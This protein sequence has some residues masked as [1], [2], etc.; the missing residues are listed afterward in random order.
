MSDDQSPS[1]IVIILKLIPLILIFFVSLI[2]NVLLARSASKKGYRKTGTNMVIL[3]QTIADLGTTCFIIPFAVP[4]VFEDKWTL[5]Q[6]LCRLNGFFNMLFTI[7][8][9]YNLSFL[10]YDRFLVIVHKNHRVLTCMQARKGIVFIWFVAIAISFPWMD[11]ASEK[12]RTVYTPG[13]YIC[14][15][16]YYHPFGA[17]EIFCLILILL[18]GAAVPTG[19]ILYSFYRILVVYRDHRVRITP[20]T[21]SNVAK[22]A[23]EQYCRSAYTSLLMIGTTMLFVLPSCFT[24]FIEGIQ[25]TNIPHS[26]ETASKWIMWCHCTIKPIIYL[27]RNKKWRKTVSRYFWSCLPKGDILYSESSRFSSQ[28]SVIGNDLGAR[29]QNNIRTLFSKEEI[30]R[31]NDL[32]LP[33]PINAWT[34]KQF[35]DVCAR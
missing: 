15:L 5:G 8:T 9:L 34:E 23:L 20:V 28:A 26:F 31:R 2:G 22:F 33:V 19:I 27:C 13:F 25:V 32:G 3:S 4:A 7:A 29:S 24:L 18:I 12:I 17:F 14:Y 35:L 16:R 21:L 1:S 6:P 30:A 11:F 10:A